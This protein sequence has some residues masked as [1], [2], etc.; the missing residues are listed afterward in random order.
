MP[1]ARGHPPVWRCTYRV[2]VALLRG[3]PVV[4]DVAWHAADQGMIL[5]TDVV[6]EV[7]AVGQCDAAGSCCLLAEC[8]AVT[9]V[10]ATQRGHAVSSLTARLSR[11]VGATQRGHAVF[12]LTARLSRWVNA[13]QRG[14]A[15]DL[16]QSFSLGEVSRGFTTKRSGLREHPC[17]IRLHRELDI[18]TR[19][20]WGQ[21]AR[22][23]SRQGELSQRVTVTD[24]CT[25]TVVTCSQNPDYTRGIFSYRLL[26]LSRF[27]RPRP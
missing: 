10:S 25:A 17:I 16:G 15:A 11:W 12:S 4:C 22:G 20:R 23:G 18:P 5:L 6:C 8:E 7:V 21:V 9:M 27:F 2:S 14:R 19:S 1:L 26:Y 24:L 13:T 3:V